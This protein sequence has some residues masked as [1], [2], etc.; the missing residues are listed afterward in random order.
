MV[1]LKKVEKYHRKKKGIPRIVKSTIG[2]DEIIYGA[3]ALNVRFPPHLDKPTTDYDVFSHAPKKDALQAERALDKK[4]GGDYFKTHPAKHKGTYKV[5]SN[6]TGEG[7][8]DFTKPEGRVPFDRIGGKKYATLGWHKMRIKKVLADPDSAYR[9]DK[10]RDA[11]NRIRI[12]EEKY[13]GKK[14]KKR[15]GKIVRLA[16]MVGG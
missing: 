5:R 10:D 8:A 1:S 15:G 12:Y 6:V 16:R 7:Y 13:K 2:R 11:R 4:F 3:R 9:H 14:K